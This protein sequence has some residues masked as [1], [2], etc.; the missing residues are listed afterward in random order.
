MKIRYVL[1]GLIL[2]FLLTIPVL[3]AD[4]DHETVKAPFNVTVGAKTKDVKQGDTVFWNE[5]VDLRKVCWEGCIF[6]REGDKDRLIDASAFTVRIFI[7]PN[8]WEPGVYNQWADYDEPHGNTQA[9]FVKEYNW[10][11]VVNET[12]EEFAGVNAT[13]VY[14]ADLPLEHKV[15]S[16]ILV[17]RGDDLHWDNLLI[18][19]QSTVWIFGRVDGAYNLSCEDGYVDIGADIFEAMEPGKYRFVVMNPGANTINEALYD[20]E[21]EVIRSPFYWIDPLEIE[22]FS[23]QVVYEKLKK[24]MRQSDDGWDEYLLTVQ[25]PEIQI[26]TLDR[27]YSLVDTLHVEGYTNLKN[28]SV[29]KVSIDEDNKT[30][31]ILKRER[32]DAVATS[33]S[34]G[35][36]RQ[37]EISVPFDE[38]NMTAGWHS[39][40]A[41]GPY[42]SFART[43]YTVRLMPE[44]Q[45]RPQE[46]YKVVGGNVFIPTPTPEIVNVTHTVTVVKIE[47]RMI[48]KEPDPAVVRKT[49]EDIAI[50]YVLGVLLVIG[51]LAGTLLLVRYLV[52]VGKRARME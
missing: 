40:Y 51:A 50:G 17:A 15:I 2:I 21:D 47:Q 10:S 36:M 49:A 29:I 25:N 12:A 22:G 8:F 6:Y 5:T 41:R 44:G 1:L 3:A 46:Y 32:F 14:E 37:W 31:D 18:T 24:F 27:Q 30:M 34:A 7:D 26:M 35:E 48:E 9:F 23:P 45:E 13:Q 4:D 43:G 39:V 42:G 33:L 16:D 19:N 28:Q 38:E 20:E 11:A 52:K